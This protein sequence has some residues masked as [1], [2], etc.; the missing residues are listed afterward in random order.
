MKRYKKLM[1]FALPFFVVALLPMACTKDKTPIPVEA[2]VPGKVYFQNDVMPIINSNCAKSGCHDAATAEEDLNLTTYAGVMKIVRPGHPA[3]SKIM[4]VIG[5]QSDEVMPPPPN[6]PLSAEQAGIIGQWI[7]QGALNNYCSLDAANCSAVNVS[8]T[9]DISGIINTYC[10]GCH[11][12]NTL[13][14]GVDLSAY[15]GVKAIAES[16]KL[17]NSVAQ[18]GM[19][20]PMPPSQKL[21]ACDVK[22]IKAWIDEG[23]KNN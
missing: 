12:G 19:A 17:Y 18:N 14:G 22:K 11:S 1:L 2:C 4:E 6:T 10:K 20:A 21:P 13:S 16:G 7:S 9:G 23:C 5:S 8:F 3:G 15:A